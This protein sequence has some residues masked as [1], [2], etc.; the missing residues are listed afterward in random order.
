MYKYLLWDIDGTIL[1]FFAAEAYAI[2]VLFDKYKLGTCSDEMIETYLRINVKYWQALERNEMTKPEILVGRFREFFEVMGIDTELAAAFNSDYQLSLGDHIVF[3]KHA[4]DMLNDEKGK[5]MLI[6]VTNGT[7][8]AQTKKLRQSGLDKVF[9]AIFISEDVGSEKPNAEYFEHVFRETG[10]T[11]RNQV[12]II[13]DSLTSDMRGGEIA[14]IDTCW[15]NPNHNTNEY[16]IRTTYEIDDI[17]KLK[18][19]LG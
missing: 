11:D 10:I 14:G 2:R 4:M 13:G 9:D 18:E 17:A 6:A 1:D 8:I 15:Y 7:K 19:I 12:L 3:V 16:G 5:Y